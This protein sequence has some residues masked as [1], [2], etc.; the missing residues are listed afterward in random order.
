VDIKPSLRD[1]L[2]GVSNDCPRCRIIYKS[3]DF[4][5]SH[6][7]HIRQNETELVRVAVSTRVL[8]GGFPRFFLQWPSAEGGTLHLEIQINAE[9]C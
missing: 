3:A 1:L 6:W 8:V 7:T 9:V 2:T 4:F 5:K